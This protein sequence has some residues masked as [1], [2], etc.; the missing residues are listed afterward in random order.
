MADIVLLSAILF[1]GLLTVIAR[2]N[3]YSA[4]SLAAA[5]SMTGAYYAYLAQFAPAF[6]VLIIY[7]G[8]VMLLVIVTAAMYASAQRWRGGYFILASIVLV[9][10]AALGVLLWTAPAPALPAS[11][12]AIAPGDAINIIV[13]LAAVAAASLLVGVEVARRA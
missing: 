8:A 3:V 11:G 13:L 4:A 2:D 6:L 10:A 5:A 1:F 7:V 12:A 9:I